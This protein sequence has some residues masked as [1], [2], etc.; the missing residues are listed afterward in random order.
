MTSLAVKSDEE[1][2]FRKALE[3]SRK[4][5][6]YENDCKLAMA[7]SHSFNSNVKKNNDFFKKYDDDDENIQLAI[8]LSKS[9]NI[10]N[11]N[12]KQSTIRE[13]IDIN[14]DEKIQLAIALSESLDI[15]KVDSK[16]SIKK[17]IENDKKLSESLQY[18]TDLLYAAEKRRALQKK[19]RRGY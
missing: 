8:A 6:K 3:E 7:L 13:N 18:N 16:K 1:E 4:S 10:S 11:V 2:N 5:I 15:S 12:S 19:G 9:L 14:E 17:Q